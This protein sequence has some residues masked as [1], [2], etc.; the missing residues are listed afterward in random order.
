ME[1]EVVDDAT[2]QEVA[3]VDDE[4][5]VDVIRINVIEDLIGRIK[6]K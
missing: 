1:N 6:A 3:D 4:D 2:L 5:I